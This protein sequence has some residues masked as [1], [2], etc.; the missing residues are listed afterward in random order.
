LT[1]SLSQNC[2]ETKA[3]CNLIVFATYSCVNTRIAATEEGSIDNPKK[4]KTPKEVNKFLERTGPLE[5]FAL[6]CEGL[7]GYPIARL[8]P[9][10]G[11]LTLHSSFVAFEAA[12][13]IPFS[14]KIQSRAHA[15]LNA[16]ETTILGE[17]L[18]HKMPV[19]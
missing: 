16:D 11:E 1:C 8:A 15:S 19:L 3:K 5:A 9:A 12:Q 17:Q 13:T 7:P 2:T 10:L 18:K 6:P 14:V 4:K